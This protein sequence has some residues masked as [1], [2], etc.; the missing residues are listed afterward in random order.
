MVGRH[1][2]VFVYVMYCLNTE[3]IEV[4]ICYSEWFRENLL[5]H[6]IKFHLFAVNMN[7]LGHII[8]CS[9]VAEWRL[10]VGFLEIIEIGDAEG[11]WFVRVS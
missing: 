1:K 9:H 3:Q 5:Q 4:K 2:A 7:I 10:A 11:K 6:S 8:P